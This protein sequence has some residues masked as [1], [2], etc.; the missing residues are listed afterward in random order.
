MTD[1]ELFTYWFD[2]C[3]RPMNNEDKTW[4]NQK[5]EE[6][7]KTNG[8]RSG[9]ALEDACLE[10]IGKRPTSV[11]ADGAKEYEEIMKVQELVR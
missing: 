6:N 2:N 10:W 11:M 8:K 5:Y 9:D 1:N 7:L 4:I 3:Y